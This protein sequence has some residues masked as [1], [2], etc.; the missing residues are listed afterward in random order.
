MTTTAYPELFGICFHLGMQVQALLE[1]LRQ[2]LLDSCL[3]ET[4]GVFL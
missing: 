4:F 3:C 1:W 2:K